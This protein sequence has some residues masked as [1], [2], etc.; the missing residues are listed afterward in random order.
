MSEEQG[1]EFWRLV[2]WQY[3]R[4]SGGKA[5]EVIL[6]RRGWMR[7]SVLAGSAQSL[8]REWGLTCSALA[9]RFDKVNALLAANALDYSALSPETCEALRGLGVEIP[10]EED[11][12]A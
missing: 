1:K 7:D 9:G 8:R 2:E 5:V 12:E 3:D 10:E 11:H 4:D 6:E